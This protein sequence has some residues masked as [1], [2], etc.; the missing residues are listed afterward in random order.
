MEVC[1]RGGFSQSFYA[2]VE[3]GK[4]KPSAMTVIR[5]A[6]ALDISPRDLFPAPQSRSREEVKQEICAL[7]ETL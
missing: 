3:S 4:V 2:Q 7:L 5:I 6:L 1:L